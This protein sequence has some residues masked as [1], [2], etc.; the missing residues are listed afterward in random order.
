MNE[1]VNIY[2][3]SY[4]TNL[5]SGTLSDYKNFGTPQNETIQRQVPSSYTGAEPFIGMNIENE[6]FLISSFFSSTPIVNNDI[7]SSVTYSLEGKV[8]TEDSKI[9]IGL[10]KK[11]IRDSIL[12]Y[13]GTLDPYTT[14]TSWGRATED[15]VKI[16]FEKSI[17]ENLIYSEVNIGKIKGKDIEDNNH[18][19]FIFMPKF[20]V[21]NYLSDKDYIGLFLMYDKFS[22]DQDCYY[23]GCGGYFSPKNLMIF[24]PMIEGYKFL[25]QNFGFHYKAF[26]GLLNMNNK[27]KNSI[28]TSF[29]GYIGGIYKVADNIFLN[30]AGE[31]RK[32]SKYNEIFSSL[33]LQYFFGNRFNITEK[34]Y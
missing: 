15:G 5:N 21:G 1:K 34:I 32:T 2:A 25:T 4:F 33:Y 29:D 9:G 14:K 26:L 16:S 3:G 31:Y 30:L 10:Y 6:N 22:K 18:I 7:K 12:S 13:V 8:K 23:Y 11:P 27:G 20:Y 19:N 17:E 28:D 24:A